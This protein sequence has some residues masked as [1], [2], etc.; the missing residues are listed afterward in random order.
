MFKTILAA[1]D[2]S[3]HSMH[4]A[5]V[6][7]QIAHRYGAALVF[8]HVMGQGPM[9][10]VELDEA[11]FGHLS[12]GEQG[13]IHAEK[14]REVQRAEGAKLLERAAH[15]AEEKGVNPIVHELADGNPAD[16]V[17]SQASRHRADLIVVGTRGLSEIGGLLLGSVSHKVSQLCKCACLMVR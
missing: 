11:E 8:V 15:G 3:R 17:L 13:R 16:V 5:M 10:K 14:V 6:A 7:S 12:M 4:A 1:I 2:G 9:P